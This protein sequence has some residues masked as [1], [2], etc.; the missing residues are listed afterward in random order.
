[1]HRYNIR[2]FNINFSINFDFPVNVCFFNQY[3]ISQVDGSAE[4][5][6]QFVLACLGGLVSIKLFRK[7]KLTRCL[8]GHTHE[9]IDQVFSHIGKLLC[10]Y[11]SEDLPTFFRIVK[12]AWSKWGST[13]VKTVEKVADFKNWIG[14]IIKTDK[15]EWLH[16]SSKV[17]CWK[18]SR[19]KGSD[20][21]KLRYKFVCQ[22]PAWMPEEG[23]QM[24]EDFPIV[25][26]PVLKQINIGTNTTIFF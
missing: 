14:P 10:K 13:V 9:N 19:D 11:D 21:V 20:D 7:V 3:S 12:G 6:N 2:I 15:N 16:E 4:N 24:F 25:D 22:D 5:I 18:L 17:L 26:G 23:I 8:V 1:M